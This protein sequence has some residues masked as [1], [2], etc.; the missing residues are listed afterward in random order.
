MTPHER[1]TTW[2]WLSADPGLVARDRA[3]RLDAP[4]QAGRGQ[5]P[6]HVV[7]GLV[8]HLAQ[9]FADDSYDRVGV[10]VWVGVHRGQGGQARSGYS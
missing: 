8:R 10:G 9:I 2:W 6:Q 7:D 3:G 1:Q 4:H 5:R